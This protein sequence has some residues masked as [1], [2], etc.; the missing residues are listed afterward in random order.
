[1]NAIQADILVSNKAS[2]QVDYA[3]AGILFLKH[4]CLLILLLSIENQKYFFV[5]LL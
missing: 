3:V 1:M 5:I 4:Y 2:I